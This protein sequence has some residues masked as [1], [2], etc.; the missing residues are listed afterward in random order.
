MT[1][2]ANNEANAPQKQD[3]PRGMETPET[4]LGAEQMED[5]KSE[6]Q[7]QKEAEQQKRK[8]TASQQGNDRVYPKNTE[9]RYAGHSHYLPSAMKESEIFRW[10]GETYPE[11]EKG[12]HTLR[13]D[14][15]QGRIV[16]VPGA[17][18][19]GAGGGQEAVAE[20]RTYTVSTRPPGGGA[21]PV[22][23]LLCADGVYE[24][25]NT[26]AGTYVAR[27]Y[28]PVTLA[29][30]YYPAI[31][32]AP[33][34]LLKRTVASF[35]ERPETEAVVDIVYSRRK[36]S[37]HLV[38]NQIEATASEVTYQPLPEDEDLVLYAEIHSHHRMH[39]F[40]SP[41]KDDISELKTGVYGV[42]GKVED[43]IPQGRFRYSCGGHFREI[44]AEDLFDDP[45][46][47]AATVRRPS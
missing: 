31:P 40:F 36:G 21:P 30:G 25:R 9:L 35:K 29:E 37:W 26:P 32:R 42:I 47:V 1:D 28:S 15:K 11:I 45:A 12:R 33:V 6:K 10:I 7:K 38:W 4:L 14:E 23:R 46:Q 5:L 39:A 2:D 16:P 34:S 22:Y 19:K 3:T 43:E 17:Q 24:V 44:P 13:Y 8:E 18:K 27:L 20:S 41:D